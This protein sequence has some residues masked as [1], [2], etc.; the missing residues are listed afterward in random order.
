VALA[1]G[2]VAP[3][4]AATLLAL[5][6]EIAHLL[7]APQAPKRERRRHFGAAGLLMD[8][9]PSAT[10]AVFGGSDHAHS[11]P[12]RSGLANSPTFL[13]IDAGATVLDSVRLT[14]SFFGF[15]PF[16]GNGLRVEEDTTGKTTATLRESAT[17][18]YYQPLAPADRDARGRYSL[19]DEGRFSA[20]MDFGQRA[21]DEVTLTTVVRVEL[22][23]AGAEVT[24]DI[25]GPAVDWA[26]ELAFRAGGTFSG[27]EPFGEHTWQLGA[28]ESAVA[29]YHNDGSSISVAIL[30]A[31]D[32]NGG[33]LLPALTAPRYEPGEEYEFPGGTDAASGERLYVSGRTPAHVR[34]RLIAESNPHSG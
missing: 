6:P 27:A 26:L 3:A 10:I 22:A 23:P 17:A 15:G 21:K 24:V 11:G 18:A 9:G 34:I 20:A 33:P 2:I 7:P 30:D 13:R 1:Q 29:S 12:I 14:R 16:R 4:H 8:H 19:T 5:Q 31:S 25:T 32:G 28:T